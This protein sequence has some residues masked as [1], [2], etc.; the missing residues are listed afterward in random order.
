MP[1]D[2]RRTPL[3]KSKAW[4]FI[5][6]YLKDPH[7][8]DYKDKFVNNLTGPGLG[9]EIDEDKVRQMPAIGHRWRNPVW[10]QEDGTIAEW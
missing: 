1:A 9:I 7:V 5:I 8:F 4:A 10:H 2:A 3:F 6:D